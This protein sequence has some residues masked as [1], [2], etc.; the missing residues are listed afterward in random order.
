MTHTPLDA[1]DAFAQFDDVI[2]TKTKKTHSSHE[3]LLEK[4]VIKKIAEDSHFQ[5]RKVASAGQSPSPTPLTSQIMKQKTYNKTFSL[6]QE[7]CNIIHQALKAAFDDN[8]EDM[9]HPSSSDIVRAALHLFAEK[10]SDEQLEII[11]KHR[12]R[13]R[14]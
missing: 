10:S 2:E 3:T 8:N 6:F 11:Q 1:F 13:G 9:P 4:D 5:S 12:G 14:K 7:E